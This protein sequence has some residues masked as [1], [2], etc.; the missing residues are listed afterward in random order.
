MK[1]NYEVYKDKVRACWIGKNI[2][3]TLGGPYEGV[4]KKLNVTGFSTQPGEPLPNDDLDLQLIWLHAMKKEGPKHVTAEVLGDYW[5]SFIP[6]FFGE[7]EFARRNMEIGI[8]PPMSGETDNNYFL[9]HSNG[10][11]IRTEIWACLCPAWPDLA[12][13]YSIE[14]AKIDHGTGEG[15]YAAMFVAA[16]E[17][18]AFVISDVRK[19][20]EI[21]LKKIPQDCRMA[22]TIRLLLDCYD[23]GVPAMDARDAI[24]NANADLGDGWFSAPSNVGFAMLGILY[25]EGDF[26]KSMLTAINCGDDTDC[27]AATVGSIL[28]IMYGTD[29]IPKDWVEY[30]GDRIITICINRGT[31][32]PAISTCTQLTDEV[33]ELAPVVLY[34]NRA[35][36][37]N[38]VE[39]INGAQEVSQEELD[40]FLL[41]YGQSEES[42]EMARS[43]LSLK[44]PNTIT[45]RCGPVYALVSVDGGAAVTAGAQKKITISFQNRFKA[46]GNQSHNVN[47][48]LLLPE[49]WS[50]SNEDFDIYVPSY[51]SITENT[52]HSVPVEITLQAPEKIAAH[53]KILLLVSEHGRYNVDA[54]PVVLLNRPAERC[55]DYPE[56]FKNYKLDY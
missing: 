53:S 39:I 12:A 30:I 33:V 4:R 36:F 43:I 19:L 37:A 26:K 15:T 24:L 38:R 52:C 21:G 13:R 56:R 44:T 50:A 40:S 42:E 2:G 46:T 31:G 27:T 11:W 41:P 5:L 35:P 28:G 10:A 20:V 48:K 32:W 3:G 34:E 54:I 17:S 47:V 6:V 8:T 22:K 16:M 9:K 7:Y 45:K 29:G 51:M 1:L 49:G 14:D 55:Y 18:A 25:G 23:K